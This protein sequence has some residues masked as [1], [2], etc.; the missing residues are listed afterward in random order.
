[1]KPELAARRA[2]IVEDPDTGMLIAGDVSD[3]FCIINTRTGAIVGLARDPIRAQQ[4]LEKR[5]KI[6]GPVH[7]IMPPLKPAPAG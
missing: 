6:F 2:E 1:M 4:I 7:K 5:N 3:C